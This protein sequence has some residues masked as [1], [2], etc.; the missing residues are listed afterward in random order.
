MGSEFDGTVYGK[1]RETQEVRRARYPELVSGGMSFTQAAKSVGISKC[2]GKVWGNGRTRSTGRDERALVDWYRGDMEEP[3]KIDGC[4]LSRVLTDDWSAMLTTER[5]VLRDWLDTDAPAL[6]ALASDAAVSSPAGWPAHESEA[7][8]L[9]ILREV[10]SGWEHYAIVL[11]E[12]APSGE[13]EG[14]L[15]GAIGLKTAEDS[16]LVTASTEYEI[17]YWTGRPY[18]G[19]GYMPEA[20]RALIEHA[21]NDLGATRIWCAHYVGNNK[22]HRVMEKCGMVFDRERLNMPVELLNE[23]RDEIVMRLDLA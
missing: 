14:T 7:Q 19:R 5:L 4:H 20:M 6:Y 13:P 2:T 22:S 1:P 12:D 3:K 18:W 9:D 15:V 16:D 17:G 11:S 8:S 10:L 21:Q 23:V